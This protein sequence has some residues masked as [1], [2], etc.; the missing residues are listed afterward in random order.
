VRDDGYAIAEALVTP[1]IGIHAA[2]DWQLRFVL[3][4]NKCVSGGKSI[5]GNARRVE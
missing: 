4:G 2:V 3:P 5:R 1:R